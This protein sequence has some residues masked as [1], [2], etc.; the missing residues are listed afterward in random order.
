MILALQ[1]ITF[2]GLP[3]VKAV[4]TWYSK[5]IETVHKITIYYQ[6]LLGYHAWHAYVLILLDSFSEDMQVELF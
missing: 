1:I 4:G 2:T 5:V 6:L 3:L